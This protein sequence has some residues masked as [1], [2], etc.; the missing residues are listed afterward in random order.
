MATQDVVGMPIAVLNL[1]KSHTGRATRLKTIMTSCTGNP[2]LPNV[3]NLTVAQADCTAYDVAVTKA[4]S[5]AAVD[6]AERKAAWV[7]AKDDAQQVLAYVQS[8]ANK[9]G[10]PAAAEAIIVSAG[11]YVK[12]VTKHVK[13]PLSATS[14][15][16]SGSVKLEALRVALLAMY[17]W[18]FSLDQKNWT[19]VTETMQ[20]HTIISGLTPGQVYYFRFTARTRKGAV[21]VS[22]IVNLMVV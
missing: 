12:T 10:S 14:I 8:V 3:P 7:V 16:P 21:I 18:S 1:G 15:A 19:S 2:S 17:Y 5:K 13:E 4:T 9:A 22:Q 11:M 20:A 6:V